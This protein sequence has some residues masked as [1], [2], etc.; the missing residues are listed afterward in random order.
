[1]NLGREGLP[2]LTRQP[3]SVLVC[4]SGIS[5]TIPSMLIAQHLVRAF[6][7]MLRAV[8]WFPLVGILTSV[9]TTAPYFSLH[10]S[11]THK[12]ANL[13]WHAQCGTIHKYKARLLKVKLPQTCMQVNCIASSPSVDPN[14]NPNPVLHQE[15]TCRLVSWTAVA[16]RARIWMR[17][18]ARSGRL[19]P[20]PA[21]SSALMRSAHFENALSFPTNDFPCT[22]SVA[23]YLFFFLSV[24]DRPSLWGEANWPV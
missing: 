13:L 4:L 12:W 23:V 10:N 1:M 7:S 21:H 20:P 2:R 18:R 8:I 16:L 24:R 22:F 15:H 6:S 17:G 3:A 14:P 9:F 19:C 5:T 11:T